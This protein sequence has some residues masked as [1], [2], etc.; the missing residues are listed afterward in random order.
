MLVEAIRWV[1]LDGFDQVEPYRRARVTDASVEAGDAGELAELDRRL[2]E[3]ARK[4]AHAMPRIRDAALSLIDGTQ[5]TAQLAD[6]VMAHLD[7]SVADKA[8]YGA[9]IQLA[10]RIERV[11]AML[12]AGLAQLQA[13]AAP[14]GGVAGI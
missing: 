3:A 7:A 6:L 11:I 4:V 10:T 12:D 13:A 14:G 8:A 1:T 2:R 5:D 9:E